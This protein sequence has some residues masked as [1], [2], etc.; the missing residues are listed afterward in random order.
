MKLQYPVF[1]LPREPGP[2][3]DWSITCPGVDDFN[4]LHLTRYAPSLESVLASPYR[5]AAIPNNCTD[6]NSQYYYPGIEQIDWSQFDLVLVSETY[7]AS[8]TQ[9]L[10]WA[11][12]IGIKNLV[13]QINTIKID[14]AHAPAINFVKLM[15]NIV[16]KPWWTVWT[17]KDN[18]YQEI[19]GYNRPF[20]FEAMLGSRRLHRDF[21]WLG[22]YST[23]LLERSIV[24]YRNLYK[25]ES[26]Q[27]FD[28]PYQ[29]EFP[30]IKIQYPSV[31]VNFDLADEV[32]TLENQSTP[33]VWGV[34]WNIYK[35]TAYSILCESIVQ[36]N[37]FEMT[38]KT[39]KMF[40]GKRMFLFFGQEYFLSALKQL[41]FQT[42]D[43]VVDESYDSIENPQ[44]RFLAVIEQMKYLA[45]EDHR[46]ILKKVQPIVDHN[47][48]RLLQFKQEIENQQ[49]N[50]LKKYI[51][52]E[53]YK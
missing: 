16:Y 6:P 29:P 52:R 27:I 33:P 8:Q 26:Q 1:Y 5:I 51:P 48:N 14:P 2:M 19:N 37:L 22:F 40:F 15:D 44:Q 10:E 18:V 23:G 21:A 53:F 42:F 25:P 24:N 50:L 36:G 45:T 34:P 13:V 12:K 17:V 46:L 28:K 30:G 38:E 7:W 39:A 41:G 11:N 35:K 31:S 43:S 32:P 49:E 4:T 47:Y 20:L 3:A 9:I